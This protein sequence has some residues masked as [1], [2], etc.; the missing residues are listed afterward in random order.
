LSEL[1]ETMSW[2]TEKIKE[3]AL[4]NGKLKQRIAELEDLKDA[5]LHA[6][7]WAREEPSMASYLVAQDHWRKI[8]DMA[9]HLQQ[10]AKETQQ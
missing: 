7:G 4:E 5:V 2:A 3:Q 1:E 9:R 6:E 8:M 10:P